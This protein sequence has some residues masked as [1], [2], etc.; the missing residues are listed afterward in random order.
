MNTAKLPNAWRRLP[1][2]PTTKDLLRLYKIK[3]KKS[4]SQN[5]IM[6]PR[7][8]QRFV[9]SAGNIEGFY[10]VEVGP[11]PGGITRAILDAKVKECHVIEKDPRFIPTLKLIREAVG[12]DKLHVSIGDCLHYNVSNRFE[13]KVSKTAWDSPLRPNLVQFG[14]LPFN[15]ATPY[16]IKLFKNMSTQSSL[17]TYGRVPS[18]LTFQHEVAHRMCATH[19]SFERC[20]L[21]VIAQ[22]YADIHYSFQLPGGAFVPPP[23][24]DV[25]VV[26][27]VPLRKPYIDLPY[28][29]IDRVVHALFVGGK[30]RQIRSSLRSLF[31]P[32]SKNEKQDLVDELLKSSDLDPK[33]S[34]PRLSMEEIKSLCFAWKHMSDN[35][36]KLKQMVE[37]T[38]LC[39][40][41]ASY[42]NVDDLEESSEFVVKF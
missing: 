24:V 7:I 18:I 25:G 8:L 10:A 11:G 42:I 29:L 16:V 35:H 39:T 30:N 4:L 32:M 22:N 31:D 21:S 41:D 3:A 38:E 34:A 26:R 1:P 5:F 12:P 37:E 40:D 27:L 15:V 6:D 33:H 9:K 28:E 23:D 14:N 2:L 19:Q 17:Y 20:R 13:G 36:R